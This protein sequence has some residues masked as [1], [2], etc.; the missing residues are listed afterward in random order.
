MCV[1]PKLLGGMPSQDN[2]ISL[3]RTLSNSAAF[4]EK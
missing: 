3:M 2:F 1:A 4:A